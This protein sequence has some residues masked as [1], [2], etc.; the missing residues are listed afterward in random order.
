M[1]LD[2]IR[3]A[4]GLAGIVLLGVAL[5]LAPILAFEGDMRI[6][7]GIGITGIVF[8]IVMRLMP[9][10]PAV[11]DPAPDEARDRTPNA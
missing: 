11:G 9:R 4:L 8:L 3:R 5:A 1:S 10:P 2:A 6:V 7:S